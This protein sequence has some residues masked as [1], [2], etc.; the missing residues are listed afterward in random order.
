MY[1]A[2][3][4]DFRRIDDAPAFFIIEP[5]DHA[6]DRLYPYCMLACH[7]PIVSVESASPCLSVTAVLLISCGAA[8]LDSESSLR[9]LSA[10]P[11]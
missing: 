5:L 6:I 2:T 11:S 9:P 3:T 8:V 4:W 7:V 10:A 1:E